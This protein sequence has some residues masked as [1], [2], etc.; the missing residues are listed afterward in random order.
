MSPE[1]REALARW[2]VPLA[3][4]AGWWAGHLVVRGL[5]W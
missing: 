5:G 4:V 2:A 1:A 3:A